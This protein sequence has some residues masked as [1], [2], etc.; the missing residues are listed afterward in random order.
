MR[1]DCICITDI[2]C[3]YIHIYIYITTFSGH[4]D[5]EHDSWQTRPMVVRDAV[6]IMYKSP[7][8]LNMVVIATGCP[9]MIIYY[10]ILGLSTSL[11]H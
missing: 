2:T 4:P 5:P 1:L 6:K 10:I 11:Y 8:L 3:L 7:S 9:K